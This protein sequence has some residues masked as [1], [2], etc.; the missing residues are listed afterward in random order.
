MR[1]GTGRFRLASAQ[2]EVALHIGRAGVGGIIRRDGGHG[3][4]RHARITRFSGQRQQGQ[5]GAPTV[6]ARGAQRCEAG[7]C[8]AGAAEGE[9]GAHQQALRVQ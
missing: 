4:Q 1:R 7:R 6:T 9:V 2:G 3:F 5:E 8:R